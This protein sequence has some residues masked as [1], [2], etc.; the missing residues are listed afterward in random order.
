[1]LFAFES[2]RNYWTPKIQALADLTPIQM[3]ITELEFSKENK[4]ILEQQKKDN[5]ILI[6]L[7]KK[8]IK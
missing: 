4:K 3:A 7:K 5:L 2:G 8:L 1:M 6:K